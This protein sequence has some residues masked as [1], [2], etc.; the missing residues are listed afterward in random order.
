LEEYLQI[1]TSNMSDDVPSLPK[2]FA[3]PSARSLGVLANAV[4][5]WKY[6]TNCIGVDSTR[7]WSE[8]LH[9]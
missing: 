6:D 2:L 8:L 4:D 5:D 1:T 7:D 9:F 3:P